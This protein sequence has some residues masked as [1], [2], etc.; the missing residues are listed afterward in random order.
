MKECIL[1]SVAQSLAAQLHQTPADQP[2]PYLPNHGAPI[3]DELGQHHGHVVVDGGGVVGPFCRV[4]HKCSQGK[5]G[6]AAN[7]G[8]GNSPHYFLLCSSPEVCHWELLSPQM[9]S[10][11]TWAAVSSK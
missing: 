6:S 2:C 10:L 9:V 5:D 7:L 1:F 11:E 3:V 8:E 4:A